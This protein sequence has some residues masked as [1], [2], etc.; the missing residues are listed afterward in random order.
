MRIIVLRRKEF[1]NRAKYEAHTKRHHPDT[2]E[3]ELLQSLKRPTRS[4][5]TLVLNNPTDVQ[6]RQST[7]LILSCSSCVVPLVPSNM[8]FQDSKVIGSIVQGST[9]SGQLGHK[10]KRRFVYLGDV[11]FLFLAT[12]PKHVFH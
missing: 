8:R 3:S 10:A 5:T 7:S 12:V 9:I 6:P 11:L 2:R 4:R 1:Y